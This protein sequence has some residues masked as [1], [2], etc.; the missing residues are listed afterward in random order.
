[1]VSLASS[2]NQGHHKLHAKKSGRSKP[3]ALV[4]LALVLLGFLR[5]RSARA[6]LRGRNVGGAD[7]ST[8]HDIVSEVTGAGRHYLTGTSLH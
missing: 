1:M 8:Y 2:V 4:I 6:S 3:A 7:S 5:N